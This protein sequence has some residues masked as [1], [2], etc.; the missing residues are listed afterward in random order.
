MKRRWR[1]AVWQA[2]RVL[3][4]MSSAPVSTIDVSGKLTSS[5]ALKMRVKPDDI[6]PILVLSA[7]NINRALCYAIDK[8][9]GAN[10]VPW[11]R[12]LSNQN[13]PPPSYGSR[14]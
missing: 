14:Y 9:R 1:S 3:A 8:I 11:F 10:E 2:P 6:F 7:K 13:G 5:I 4:L 12:N